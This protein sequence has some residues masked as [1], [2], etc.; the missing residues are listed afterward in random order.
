MRVIKLDRR[1][2]HSGQYSAALQFSKW[3]F[4]K[5]RKHWPYRDA[6]KQMFGEETAFEYRDPNIIPGPG[7]WFFNEH[8]R[9]DRVKYRIN[10][11]DERVIAMLEL[12]VPHD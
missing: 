2:K 3:E 4:T 1:Y 8:Y 5:G 12:M 7:R 6:L 9:V 10:I 11:K